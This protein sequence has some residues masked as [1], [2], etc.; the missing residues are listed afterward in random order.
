MLTSSSNHLSNL[1]AIALLNGVVIEI[2]DQVG[3]HYTR[4]CSTRGAVPATR[5]LFKNVGKEDQHRLVRP[6]KIHTA[7]P[8]MLGGRN[9]LKRLPNVPPLQLG[10]LPFNLV[11]QFRFGLAEVTR[12]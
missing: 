3:V 5:H 9:R 10:Y 7:T 2:T 1:T 8:D 6:V 12:Q 4:L 11:H